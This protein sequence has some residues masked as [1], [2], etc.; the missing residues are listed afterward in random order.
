MFLQCMLNNL[1]LHSNIGR[2]TYNDD[3][4]EPD[5]PYEKDLRR[6]REFQEIKIEIDN[7]YIVKLSYRNGVK[8]FIEY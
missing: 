4:N 5:T 7:H 3:G 2:E 8:M 6:C 1:P